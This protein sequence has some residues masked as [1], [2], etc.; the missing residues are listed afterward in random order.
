M[1]MDRTRMD[2]NGPSAAAEVNMHD[3]MMAARG[4]DDSEIYTRKLIEHHRG[5]IS[6]SRIALRKTRDPRTR[7][8]AQKVIAMQTRGISGLQTWAFQ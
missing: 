3:K 4:T 7:A 5:A 8:T 2:M 1:Q 6:L